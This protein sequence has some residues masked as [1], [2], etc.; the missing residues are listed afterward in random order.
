M[1]E[2]YRGAGPGRGRGQEA[3]RGTSPGRGRGQEASNGAS[4]GRGRGRGRGRGSDRGDPQTGPTDGDNT[5]ADN[6]GDRETG[7]DVTGDKSGESGDSGER[8]DSSKRDD[9][10]E[11]SESSE[12]G[13]TDGSD[14]DPWAVRVTRIPC[15][16][17]E[18]EKL[19]EHFKC[20]GKLDIYE[21]SK[22]EGSATVYF[23]SR[24]SV[25]DV[26][27]FVVVRSCM[28]CTCQVHCM[29]AARLCAKLHVHVLPS[30][31]GE[32]VPVCVQVFPLR[33]IGLASATSQPRN[34][35]SNRQN[36][37]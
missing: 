28:F 8:S 18:E 30:S 4:P 34:R 31:H 7:E 10:G 20:F 17:N 5:S 15:K 14:E 25:D 12:P 11:S 29:C 23:N 13:P 6:S 19:Q 26:F 33:P 27:F 16:N 9:S 37:F 36:W 22:S 1:Q 2:A 21:C 3:N 32:S 24:V 35:R